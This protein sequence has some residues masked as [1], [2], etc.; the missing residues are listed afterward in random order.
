MIARQLG[1]Y[2]ELLCLAI[3]LNLLED[4]KLIQTYMCAKR[5]IYLLARDSESAGEI[6]NTKESGLLRRN[7]FG[8][9]PNITGY[10]YPVIS[11]QSIASTNTRS[12]CRSFRICSSFRCG[13]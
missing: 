10:I 8:I 9:F 1:I 3:I 4:S 6:C 5:Y 12:Y 7:C 11:G 2:T 13:S